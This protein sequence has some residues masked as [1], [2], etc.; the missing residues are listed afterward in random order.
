MAVE[1]MDYPI[2]DFNFL[3]EVDFSNGRHR[4]LAA[5][6]L[7]CEYLPMLVYNENLDEFKKNVRTREMSLPL[8]KATYDSDGTLNINWASKNNSPGYKT[9]NQTLLQLNIEQV[10]ENLDNKEE[11]D[12]YLKSGRTD[13]TSEQTEEAK[14]RILSGNVVDF[15]SIN[16]N[17]KEDSFNLTNGKEAMMAAHDL[18]L[19][20]IPML[21]S[22]ENLSDFKKIIKTKD[23]NTR[24][25][26]VVFEPEST[27]K[28]TKKNKLNLNLY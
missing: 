16:Y 5:A 9:N 20:F 1:P 2:V 27:I 10:F 28:K 6:Q 22:N 25:E 13:L 19:K 3:D 26:S 7:G 17:K 8:D 24:L 15:S 23:M 12:L 21:V 14:N 11:E 4:T 18:G